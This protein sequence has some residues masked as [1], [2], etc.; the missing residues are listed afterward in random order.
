MEWITDNNET[1]VEFSVKNFWGL[2][3]VKGRMQVREGRLELAGSEANQ[4]SAYV[5]IDTTSINSG[6]TR[7]DKH[8]KT[9]DFFEVARYPLITF[10]GR[11][12]EQVDATNF[13]LKGE[14]TMR[15]ITQPVI[16]EV[17]RIATPGDTNIYFQASTTLLR[18]DFG[19]TSSKFPIGREV[20]INLRVKAVQ[21]SVK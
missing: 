2:A 13:R 12:V 5:E 16:L 20:T 18:H 6:N 10:R 8:L 15:E 4:G 3:T 17:S 19:L 1:V 21:T 11:N 14:L 7:R 9:A